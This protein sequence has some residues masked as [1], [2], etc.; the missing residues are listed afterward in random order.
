MFMS[1]PLPP[2]FE[3]QIKALLSATGRQALSNPTPQAFTQWFQQTAPKLIPALLEQ[4]PPGPEERSRFVRF[5]ALSLLS[6][7]PLPGHGLQAVGQPKQGRNDPCACGSGKKFKHCCGDMSM[8]PLFGQLNLL[9]Y[10]LDAYPKSR[11]AEVCTS[12]ASI[13]AVADTAY[14]WLD[15]G[16]AERASALLE[17][18]FAGDGPLTARLAPLFN[19]LMDTWLRLGRSTKRERLIDAILQ[20]GDRLL[21]SDALQRRTTMLA[22]RGDHAG[23]WRNFKQASE[24]NPNDPALSFLEVTTLMSEGR[25]SEAKLRAQWWAAFL[26]KQRDPQLADLVERLRDMA[27]DPHEAMLDVATSANIDLQRLHHLFL[28]APAPVPRHRFDVFTNEDEDFG[29]HAVASELM[30]DA[31]LAKLEKRWQKVFPQSKPGLTAVQND[32]VEVWD[33]APEWLDLLQKHPELWLSF[34]VLDDLVMAVDTVALAGVAERLLT[35]MCERAAEQLRVTLESKGLGPVQC[36][37]GEWSNRPILRPIA[38]LAYLCMDAGNWQRFMEIARWLVLE[39]NPNDN[40]G[41]RS[42]LSCAYVRFERWADVTALSARYPDDMQPAMTL[43]AVLAA[44]ALGDKDQAGQRLVQAQRNHPVLVKMLLQAAAPKPVKPDGY[45]ITVGGKY[46]A[47][48][49][50]EKMREFWA[51][52]NALEWARAALKPTKVKAKPTPPGQQ[53]LL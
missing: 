12:H 26:S 19:L 42:D 34:D 44:L 28:A 22:D 30:P 6:G 39:L 20:R 17:P 3:L 9:R 31:A 33:N 29:S 40:H 53:G 15:E 35:P 4:I 46:E 13:D 45:G 41:L 11:L 27:Q 18:Y 24:L 51:R 14:Q 2:D 36:H 25:V 50:V 16:Q 37:W 23:A 21:K 52:H 32:A 10:V 38:H 8:P 5:A 49:Y 1:T 7:L 48:L 43:N 47:W